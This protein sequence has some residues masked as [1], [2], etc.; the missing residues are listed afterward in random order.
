MLGTNTQTQLHIGLYYLQLGAIKE[1]LHQWQNTTFKNSPALV[2]ATGGYA[3][4]IE[5]EPII[6]YYLPD[7]VLQG[8]EIVW[9]KNQSV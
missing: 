9:K 8:L 5:H 7:L 4:L 6:D 3:K 1:I 2:I